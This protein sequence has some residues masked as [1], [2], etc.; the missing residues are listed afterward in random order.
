MVGSSLHRFQ[1]YSNEPPT[2]LPSCICQWSFVSVLRCQSQSLVGL[3]CISVAIKNLDT[4]AWFYNW[5]DKS[6]V[7]LSRSH[8]FFARL[9]ESLGAVKKSSFSAFSGL[10]EKMLVSPSR[11]V[12]NVPFAIPSYGYAPR[13]TLKSPRDSDQ[14]AVYYRNER[15]VQSV[16][17]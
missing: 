9:F 16:F 4:K 17:F 14:A 6:T 5:S 11:K 3:V 12:S 10:A 7:Q 1:W 13:Y 15:E 8:D 2:G